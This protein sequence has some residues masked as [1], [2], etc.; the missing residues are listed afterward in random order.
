M[1]NQRSVIST[2]YDRKTIAEIMSFTRALEAVAY[3]PPNA[4]GSGY[5][6]ASF[7]RDGILKVLDSFG[8]GKPVSAALNYTGIG[9]AWNG[10]AARRAIS[11]TSRATR[12]NPGPATAAAAGTYDQSR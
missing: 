11:Q 8:L 9:N 2:L 6:A 3:K 5:T 7:I 1:Q 12:P 10:A 4:S